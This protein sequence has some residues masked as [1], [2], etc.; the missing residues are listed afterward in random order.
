MSKVFT[1]TRT[2]ARMNK[3]LSFIHSVVKTREFI[4]GF[5]LGFLENELY[6]KKKRKIR[7]K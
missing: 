5:K 7:Q 2:E 4:G 3:I 6:H 1:N